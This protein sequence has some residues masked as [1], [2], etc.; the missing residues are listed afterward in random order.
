[1]MR[2]WIF[3]GFS[4]SLNLDHPFSIVLSGGGGRRPCTAADGAPGLWDPTHP[5]THRNCV[6]GIHSRQEFHL[7]NVRV[8][9]KKGTRRGAE[10]T[11][12]LGHLDPDQDSA[13]SQLLPLSLLYQ[14]LSDH[15][16]H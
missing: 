14:V 6:C 9:S 3:I 12:H 1:M 4:V 15:Q 8:K 5:H 16:A 11:G 13:S 7:L 2:I 10:E